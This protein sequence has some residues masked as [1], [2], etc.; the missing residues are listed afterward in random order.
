[1]DWRL[2]TWQGVDVTYG[3]PRSSDS[4]DIRE[5]HRLVPIR[6]QA[7]PSLAGASSSSRLASV[8]RSASLAQSSYS[9]LLTGDLNFDDF[10]VLPSD[11]R[12]LSLRVHLRIG[13]GILE[14]FSLFKCPAA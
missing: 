5:D 1:M 3:A 12:W 2:V 11:R 6:R 14:T 13:Y 9:F 7:I 8:S 4:H 10:R